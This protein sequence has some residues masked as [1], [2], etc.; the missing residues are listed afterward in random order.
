MLT[1][2]Q[3]IKRKSGILKAVTIFITVL[4]TI[5]LVFVLLYSRFGISGFSGLLGLEKQ[6][7]LH[8]EDLISEEADYLE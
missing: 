3:F 6:Q 8:T 4:I 5:A 7:E 1:R 2:S